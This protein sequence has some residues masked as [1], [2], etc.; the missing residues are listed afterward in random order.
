MNYIF[1]NNIIG[2][3]PSFNSRNYIIQFFESLRRIEYK[4]QIVILTES[5]DRLKSMTHGLNVTFIFIEDIK[6]KYPIPYCSSFDDINT[7]RYYYY[8][9]YIISNNVNSDDNILCVDSRD[10]LFQTNPFNRMLTTNLMFG[11]EPLPYFNNWSEQHFEI[12]NQ[13]DPKIFLTL[14]NRGGY[15][16]NSNFIGTVKN[17]IKLVNDITNELSIIYSKVPTHKVIL[18]QILINK[19]IAI[20]KVPYITVLP[21]ENNLIVSNLLEEQYTYDGKTVYNNQ[22]PISILH[23]YDRN[24]I[25][26][27]KLLKQYTSL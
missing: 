19:L 6:L 20:N 16:I 21:H 10:V 14:K 3:D 23:Q 27:E 9:D 25:I 17:F 11:E 2:P 26:L 7:N 18:D 15:T 1:S 13:I 4:D 22:I 8:L 5:S 12:Y 24:S